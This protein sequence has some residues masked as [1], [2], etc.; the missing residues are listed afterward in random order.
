MVVSVELQVNLEMISTHIKVGEVVIPLGW[1]Q[2]W[3][4]NIQPDNVEPILHQKL[5]VLWSKGEL[6]VK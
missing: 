5:D 2:P 3:P 6:G 1:F 4:C